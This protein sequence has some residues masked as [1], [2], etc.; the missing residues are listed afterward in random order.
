MECTVKNTQLMTPI[1]DESPSFLYLNLDKA[2]YVLRNSYN[3]A[4]SSFRQLIET[5]DASSDQELLAINDNAWA[6]LQDLTQ[7]ALSNKT[8]I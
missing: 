8:K 2:T 4:Q 5:P 3:A 7:D 1:T 6:M